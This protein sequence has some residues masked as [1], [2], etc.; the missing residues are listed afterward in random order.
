MTMNESSYN[1][2]G[3]PIETEVQVR[4]VVRAAVIMAL[5][6][7]PTVLLYSYVMM[8][9]S[10]WQFAVAA[11]AV[12]VYFLICLLTIWL[13]RRGRPTLGARLLIFGYLVGFLAFSLAI[14]NFGLLLGL[15]SVFLT[16]FLAGQLL[17][18][19]SGR[20]MFIASIIIGTITYLP[21]ILF[22]VL[23]TMSDYRYAAPTIFYAYIPVVLGLLLLI[24]AYYALRRFSHFP[25]QTKL[26]LVLLAVALV[27]MGMLIFLNYWTTQRTLISSANEKLSG[28]AKRTASSVD[29][30]ISSNIDII[31]AE[32][33]L[34]VLAEY[35]SL[36]SDRRAGSPTEAQALS[37]LQILRNKDR[38]NISSYGLLDLQGVNVLD[39]YTPETGINRSSHD[40]FTQPVQ[41]GRPYV[42]AVE[43]TGV[44]GAPVIHFSAPVRNGAGVIVGVLRLRY[45]ASI[46]QHL[47]FQNNDLVG[48]GSFAFLLDEN[49]IRL[50]HGSDTTLNFK[51]VIPLEEAKL[52]ELQAAKRLPDSLPQDLF[53]DLPE[54]VAGLA[55]VDTATPYFTAESQGNTADGG[56]EQ[57]A[58]VRLRNKPWI[59]AFVQPQDVFLAP[60]Q[61]QTRLTIL[62]TVAVVIMVVLAA[63]GLGRYLA[64]SIVRLTETARRIS[65]G[66]LDARA[67]VEA[68]DETGQLAAAFNVMTGR[69][70]ELI[71]SL[72][73]Q[74]QERTRELSLSI[75]VGQRAATMRNLSELLP[76]I[77]EFIRERFNLYYTQIYFV[78]DV[79]ENLILRAGTGEVGQALL[80][81]RHS[82]PIGGQSIGGQVAHSGQSIVVSDTAQS[83]IHQPNELLPETRSELAVPLLVEGRV[84]GVLDMQASQA[85]TFTPDNLTA[86]EALGT[87]LASS[88]DSAQQWVLAQE[89][90]QKAEEAVRRLTREGWA[91]RL[92]V[93]PAGKLGFTYDLSHLAPLKESGPEPD[94]HSN[95]LSAAVLVQQETIGR[96]AVELPPG[97]KWTEE[98]HALLVT[99]AQQ[100][101][102]KAETLRLFEITQQRAAREQIVRQITD[103]VRASR[104]IDSALKTAAEE[105]ARALGTARAV[106][107]LNLDSVDEPAAVAAA[108]RATGAQA[109]ANEPGNNGQ[110][111]Q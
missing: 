15:T 93:R 36:P 18:G 84:L 32:A 48:Q 78:D 104:T 52:A 83:D 107:D 10:A 31:R 68:E 8:T 82:L 89:A 26:V 33:Q 35:M 23:P 1:L 45:N 40:Y 109:A 4:R 77:T 105:L 6:A 61:A 86:F 91:D 98:E 65:S 47:M 39:T 16:L 7:G 28:A 97:R 38:H 95:T 46:L 70:Q 73:D 58:A 57:I 101:G 66:D 13:A 22:P 3:H 29:S 87:Q 111:G 30:F 53:T 63:T 55:R 12:F 67:S 108:E 74:V 49:Y 34:A 19:K 81:R 43:F 2:S 80:A 17:P 14:A 94:G 50:A 103:K 56:K 51:G 25:L 72:E 96:L 62:L 99:V 54:L 75:E 100:L 59:V 37:V 64:G 5:G 9:T 11:L 60:L 79:G 92:A 69:L 71:G 27:S 41:T 24:Y 44:A 102:Q 110:N 106:I 76:T 85:N 90:Q 21:D 88:I 20:Q 42:S